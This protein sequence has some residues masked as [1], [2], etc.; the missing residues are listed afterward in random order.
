MRFPYK[1][2]PLQQTY[3]GISNFAVKHMKNAK[4]LYQE[5]VNRIA[6]SESVDEIKTMALLIMEN[7]FDV[8][9]T[10]IVAEKPILIDT[11]S[12]VLLDQYIGRL[13]TGEPV[14]YILGESYFFGRVFRVEPSVLIPRPET[15]LLISIVL[16]WK[17]SLSRQGPEGF[18]VL[19]IGTG[20][21]CISVTLR[22]ESPETAVFATDISDAAIAVAKKNA[23]SYNANITFLNHDILTE[24]IP[25][26]DIDVIVSNPPYVTR[27]ESSDMKENVLR[28]EPHSA[29]FVP[30]DDPLI[31]YREI[32]D[33]SKGVLR[34][35]GMV[36]VEINEKFG[37]E[38][39]DLF[40]AKG[41]VEVKIVSDVEGKARVVRGVNG[42]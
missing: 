38:V 41:F 23:E 21:G 14:Q 40:M 8:S 7:I 32:L 24:D 33:K 26:R 28:F 15:E 37:K 39:A 19:D 42:G 1:S 27:S 3:P 30:D 20:S 25:F 16:S 9:R 18:R 22:L 31:F 10:D 35:P 29:L 34:R 5:V 12:L 17:K 6:L 36:V 4:T 2:S 13:N 11:N